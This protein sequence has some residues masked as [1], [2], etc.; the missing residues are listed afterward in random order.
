MEI[1]DHKSEV[2]LSALSSEAR[3]W[4]RVKASYKP[5]IQIKPKKA[6][7]FAETPEK[8]KATIEEVQ[9]ESTAIGPTNEQNPEQYI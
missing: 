8:Q 5:V 2:C 9:I 1:W 7:L 6:V 4:V 3:Q